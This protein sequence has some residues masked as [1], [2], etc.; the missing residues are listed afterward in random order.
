[1]RLALRYTALFALLLAAGLG[2]L[3]WAASR[4]VDT[5]VAAGLQ[6]EIAGLRQLD[7]EYGRA[8]LIAAL[9]A[10][11][12]AVSGNR[13]YFL[14]VG[15]SGRIV[16]GDLTAWPAHLKPDGRVRTIWIEDDLRAGLNGDEDGYWPAVATTLADGA[17]LLV[18]RSE[19]QAEELQEFIYSTMAVILSVSVAL[20]LTLG[21]LL[22]RTMLQRIDT[23]NMTARAITAGELD[24]RVPM[25]GRNDEFDELAQHL[26]AMLARITQLL[27]GMHR[28]TDNVAHDLRRPLTRLRNRLEVTLL[29]ARD[30]AQYR[31]TMTEAIADADDL[32]RTFNALLEIAQAESGSFRGEWRDVDIG[33]LATELGELYQGIAEERDQ[34]LAIVAAP[35]AHVAGNRHL[36]AEALSNLLENAV[37]YTPHG[38]RI[39]LKVE[40]LAAAVRVVVA[41]SGP[42]IPA[43]ERERVLER[44]VR[45]ESARS[46]SGNGLGLSLVRAVAQLHGATL[47]LEDNA[48]G[49]EVRID[50]PARRGVDTAP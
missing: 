10:A 19:R 17:R 39:T 27:G 12:H 40:R 44:F 29:E 21:W 49:L 22:G 23:I 15:R 35:G 11:R 9:D 33:E 18:V 34:A 3:Y 42:G 7:G 5:Q 36:L 8:R 41:D 6:G 24:R 37:K 48:P 50:F 13:R 2:T 32:I 45:L 43:P 4:Y 31:Q 46:T 38:G 20:A 28:V 1:M 30:T 25:S 47:A 16:A 26:N 14:L